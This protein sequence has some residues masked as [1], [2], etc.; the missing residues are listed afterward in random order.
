MA[1]T[2]NQSLEIIFAS[3]YDP[4]GWTQLAEIISSVIQ[5]NATS[6]MNKFRPPFE[7][8]KDV[9]DSPGNVATAVTCID[10]PPLDP[11][12]KPDVLQWEIDASVE[13]YQSISRHFGPMGTGIFFPSCQHWKGK[14]TERFTGPFNH[15]LSNDVLVIGNT[16]DVRTLHALITDVLTPSLLFWPTAGDTACRRQSSSFLAAQLIAAHYSG[17]QRGEL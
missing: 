4:R 9:P 13:I 5:G 3:L 11:S 14:A 15:S 16:A 2:K 17:W 10:S 6:I 8:E 1:H 7:L 12:S